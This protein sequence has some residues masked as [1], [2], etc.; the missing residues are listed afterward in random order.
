VNADARS[1]AIVQAL[2]EK[3]NARDLDGFTA[4]LTEDVW[5]HDL[6]MPHPPVVGRAAV[7]EF[8]EIT[9]RAFPD[10]RYEIR[11]PICVS[12]D[13][14]HVVLPW[15]ITATNSAPIDPPGLAPTGRRV[16]F[17]GLDYLQIRD[18]LVARI[19]TRFD[20]ADAIEQLMGLHLR[21]AA[22]SWRERAFVLVQRLL[23]AWVR[24]R[25]RRGPRPAEE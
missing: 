20:P 12:A 6:G 14:D 17:D 7:R 19:E 4:L 3:W 18:G 16:H 13:G 10:F 5:W 25:G 23:A 21:P 9:L 24:A 15:T 8:S 2:L 1:A 11:G 22:G